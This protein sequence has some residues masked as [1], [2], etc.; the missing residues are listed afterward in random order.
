MIEITNRHKTP[1]SLIVRSKVAP[2]SFTTLTVPGV[3]AGKNVVYIED[4]RHTIYV[5]RAESDK[6]ISTRQV[7][8]KP[9]KGE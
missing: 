5:D 8:N 6:L 4:E 7:E 1:V 9:S 2:R 3:G